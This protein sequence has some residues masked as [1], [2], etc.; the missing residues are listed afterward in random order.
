MV[1]DMNGMMMM[2]MMMMMG[3]SGSKKNLKT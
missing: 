1:T 3:F 2:M